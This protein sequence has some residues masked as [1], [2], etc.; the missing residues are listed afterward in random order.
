MFLNRW[1]ATHFWVAGTYNWVAKICI[2]VVFKDYMGRQIVFY[3][4]LWV[5]NYQLLGT[6]DLNDS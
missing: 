3:P 5:A 4:V 1:V 6:T 2:I